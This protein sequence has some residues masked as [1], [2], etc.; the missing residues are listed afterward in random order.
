MRFF[1]FFCVVVL[2]LCLMLFLSVVDSNLQPDACPGL[3]KNLCR[4]AG[5]M[6]QSQG[7]DSS[8][9]DDTIAR[10]LWFAYDQCG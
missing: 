2:V 4:V 9:Q 1:V 10:L 3:H 7:H 8:M 6:W 5:L